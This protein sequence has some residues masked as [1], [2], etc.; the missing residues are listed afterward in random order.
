M[1][2]YYLE[3]KEVIA[4]I[5]KRTDIDGLGGKQPTLD[6]ACD[7]FDA[8]ANAVVKGIPNVFVT[9]GKAYEDKTYW[10]KIN[11][12][13]DEALTKKLIRKFQF[14]FAQEFRK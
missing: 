4:A 2:N 3:N 8:N 12:L 13:H 11:K 14:E 10:E 6:I 9:C 5:A 1:K 7:V